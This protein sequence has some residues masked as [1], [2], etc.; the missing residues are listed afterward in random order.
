[1]GKMKDLDILAESEPE[2]VT[3]LFSYIFDIRLT[4]NGVNRLMQ[5]GFVDHEHMPTDLGIEFLVAY[6][7]KL[8]REEQIGLNAILGAK[9]LPHEQFSNWIDFV[10]GSLVDAAIIGCV[11]DGSI[12]VKSCASGDPSDF[13]FEVAT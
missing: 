12:R 8:G 2:I 5:E 1:M 9:E 11:A 6:Q 3:N 4:D 13:E 10:R 7:H